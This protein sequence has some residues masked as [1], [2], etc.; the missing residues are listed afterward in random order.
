MTI[1]FLYCL[2]CREFHGLGEHGSFMRVCGGCL[3]KGE[4]GK[5]SIWIQE[6]IGFRQ[7][8]GSNHVHIVANSGNLVN[9]PQ[10]VLF[11]TAFHSKANGP[12]HHLRVNVI[13]NMDLTFLSM[14]TYAWTAGAK[15]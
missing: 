8:I 10:A 1:Y 11:M 12:S 7:N 5:D 15:S 13:G 6:G 4:G 9:T 3:G 14:W 2:D